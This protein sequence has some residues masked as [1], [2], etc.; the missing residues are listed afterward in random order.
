[1]SANLSIIFLREERLHWAPVGVAA[2]ADEVQ[3]LAEPAT[4]ARLREAL[5][6]DDHRVVFAAPGAD[7]RLFDMP[8]SREEKRH[9]DQALPFALEERLTD[10]I[11]SLHF[12]KVAL[13][14]ESFGVAVASL[15][16]MHRW[17]EQ[18][19]S[20]LSGAPDTEFARR[21]SERVLW[22]PEQLLLPWQEG[23]WLICR[24]GDEVILRFGRCAGTRIEHALL[25]VLL[26]SLAQE[27]RPEKVVFYGVDETADRALMSEFSDEPIDWRRGDFLAAAMLLGDL[28]HIPRLDQ[29]DFAPSLPFARWWTLWKGV[30]AALLVALGVHLV[31]GWLELS[32]LEDANLALRAETEAVYRALNPRGVLQ[33]PE[34]QLQRQLDA[35]KGSSSSGSFLP[36]LDPL[37]QQLAAQDGVVLGNLNYSGSNGQIRVSLLAKDFAQVEQIRAGLVERG[38]DATLD[39]S[40]RSG[41]GVRARLRLEAAR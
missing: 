40:S 30:A 41:Q 11:A 2:R 15:E 10:D 19:D 17:R 24:D 33:D 27:K 21:L 12:A 14:D 31:G 4:V 16:K 8:V 38:L 7:V 34:R 22:L 13:D 35:L 3:D 26:R 20:I 28:A 36:L 9:L 25:E 23:E 32:R 37:A 39:N 1:M 29:G 18:L 6:V 5:A